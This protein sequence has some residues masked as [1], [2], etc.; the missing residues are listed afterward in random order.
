M[1]VP[2]KIIYGVESRQKILDGVQEIA[3]AVTATLGPKGANVLIDDKTPRP[4]ITKDG[5]TVAKSI[6]FSD[7]YKRV[8]AALVKEAAARVDDIAGDGTTTTTLII[9]ELLK[10]T[11]KLAA[12]GFDRTE[13][14]KGVEAATKSA[15]AY[16]EEHKTPVRTLDDIYTVAK[17]SANG[18]EEIASKIKEAYSLIGDNGTVHIAHGNNVAGETYVESSD[19]LDF[20]SGLADTT[21]VNTPDG[22]ATFEQPKILVMRETGDEISPYE[23]IMQLCKSN[24]TP[25]VIV[26]PNFSDIFMVRVKAKMSGTSLQMALVYSPGLSF[27]KARLEDYLADLSAMLDTDIYTPGT[28][29]NIKTLD[30]LGDAELIK[31]SVKRATI[32][33]EVNQD[34]DRYKSLVSSIKSVI[35]T[36]GQNGVTPEVIEAAKDRLAR[37]TGGVAIVRVGALTPTELEEKL[38]LYEDASRA[39]ETSIKFG[40][41]LPGGGTAMLRAADFLKKTEKKHRELSDTAK[42]GYEAVAETLREPAKRIIASVDNDNYQ[43]IMSS[44][45]RKKQFSYGYNARA[46]KITDMLKDGII[47]AYAVEHYALAYSSSIAQ[48]FIATDCVVTPEDENVRVNYETN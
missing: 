48:S 12:L 41:V 9:S 38:A 28:L 5:V 44:I 32:T 6:T 19:G 46:E 14:R 36:E 29:S 11:A 37:L 47:D 30:D 42:K 24:S 1:A 4:L 39:V 8:G 45:L 33:A 16:L 34:S 25:L 35:D 23:A 21:F 20:D 10:K 17:V 15:L 22:T 3:D 31:A 43:L 27:Q 2:V 26:A 40:G 13:I 7:S 18:N